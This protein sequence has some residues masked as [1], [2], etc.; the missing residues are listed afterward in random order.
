MGGSGSGLPRESTQF[1]HVDGERNT[2]LVDRVECVEGLNT[3]SDPRESLGNGGIRADDFGD[4]G[5]L[6]DCSIPQ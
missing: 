1:C 4:F 2:G 6:S 5:D 3:S